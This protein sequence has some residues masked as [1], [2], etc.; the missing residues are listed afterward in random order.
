MNND[1]VNPEL[2]NIIEAALLATRVPLTVDKLLTMFPEQ[3]RPSRDEVKEALKALE[4]DYADRSIE[5]KQID[6]GFRF[7]TRDKYAD[8]M[9]QLHEEKPPRYSRA[10]LETLAIIIYRQPVTRGDIEDIRGVSVSTDIMRVL[11]EREWIRQVGARD[12]PGKPGLYG[13]TRQFLE[14][15]NLKSLEELPPLQQM[16]DLAAIGADLNLRLNL[17]P[18]PATT[19]NDP[20]QKNADAEAPAADAATNKPDTDDNGDDDDDDDW[21]DDDDDDMDDGLDEDKE[22]EEEVDEDENIITA[23]S[24]DDADTEPESNP[25]DERADADNQQPDNDSHAASEDNSEMEDEPATAT[26]QRA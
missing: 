3:S 16:R 15:F 22:V 7:Q 23:D 10:L 25:E 17:E 13:T 2:K 14:Y 9:A 11:Q 8:W 5:L 18:P 19:A 24:D 12:V 20:N 6:R 1:K 26:P 4:N 21:D